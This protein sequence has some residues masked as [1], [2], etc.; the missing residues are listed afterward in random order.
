MSKV[1]SKDTS[2]ENVGWWKDG[3]MEMSAGMTMTMVT[4][5]SQESERAIEK[6]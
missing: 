4:R 5:V 2:K 1:T 6:G 3:E